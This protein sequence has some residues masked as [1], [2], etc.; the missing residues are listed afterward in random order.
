MVIIHFIIIILCWLRRIQLIHVNW[1][2]FMKFICIIHWACQ[3]VDILQYRN[4]FL[5]IEKDV[6]KLILLLHEL[7]KLFLN[8]LEI[9]KEPGKKEFNGKKLRFFLHFGFWF[10]N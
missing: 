1:C 3:I 4:N 5:N 7:N 10:K 2:F 8:H 6:D 9:T